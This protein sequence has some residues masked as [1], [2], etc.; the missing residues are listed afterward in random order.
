[1]VSHP[2]VRD[3]ITFSADGTYHQTID[4]E[5]P[6]THFESGPNRWWYESSP[7]GVG[8]VH[9]EG[10]QE[11]GVDPYTP[12]GT[13]RDGTIPWADV[14]QDRWVTP[15]AGEIFL[16]AIGFPKYDQEEQP[17]GLALLLFRGFEASSWAYASVR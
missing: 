1:M 6:L 10:F 16:T 3:V 7:I 15:P 4:L 9:L 2:T 11:C 17:P 12:C 8:Y 14:C 5:D 13:L